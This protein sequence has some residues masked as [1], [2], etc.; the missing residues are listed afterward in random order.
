VRSAAANQ[1]RTLRRR[2]PSFLARKSI[3]RRTLRN[4]RSTTSA[5][6]RHRNRHSGRP[7]FP[8]PARDR[9]GILVQVLGRRASAG[10]ALTGTPDLLRRIGTNA[11]EQKIRTTSLMWRVSHLFVY[12]KRCLKTDL[13]K[14]ANSNTN[15]FECLN[16]HCNV[17]K[18]SYLIYFAS[19]IF[20]PFSQCKLWF[21]KFNSKISIDT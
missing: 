15:S 3:F 7:K 5:T 2:R 16:Y 9:H 17:F 10:W 6:I 13:G 11:E 12:L 19:E 21:L 4:R 1:K 20:C 18:I 8:G 14:V